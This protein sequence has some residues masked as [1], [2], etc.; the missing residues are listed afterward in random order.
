M[1]VY[2]KR[3]DIP[4]TCRECRFLGKTACEVC[5]LWDNNPDAVVWKL[6]KKKNGL[7]DPVRG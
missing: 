5:L 3:E 2:M 4:K 6:D 1:T 7:P